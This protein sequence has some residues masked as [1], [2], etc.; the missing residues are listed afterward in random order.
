MYIYIYVCRCAG[1]IGVL[2]AGTG[3]Q[4][5]S[6]WS[7]HAYVCCVCVGVCALS[8][9]PLDRMRVKLIMRPVA[10]GL[11]AI[12]ANTLPKAMKHQLQGV[13]SNNTDA[14]SLQL[15]APKTLCKWNLAYCLYVKCSLDTTRVQN[16]LLP[17]KNLTKECFVM[18][19]R[20]PKEDTASLLWR[21]VKVATWEFINWPNELYK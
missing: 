3:Q 8:C 21:T 14:S 9:V 20:N 16:V 15:H 5:W 11:D 2:Y 1:Q 7:P 12:N 6:T 17:D 10:C 19:A 4:L 18:P 13:P